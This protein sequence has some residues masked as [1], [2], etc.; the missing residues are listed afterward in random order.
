MGKKERDTQVGVQHS[1][2]RPQRYAMEVEYDQ[3]MEIL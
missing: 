2:E 1:K 3:L